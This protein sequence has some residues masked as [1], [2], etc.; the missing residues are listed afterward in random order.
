MFLWTGYAVF[1]QEDL[2]KRGCGGNP[3]PKEDQEDHGMYSAEQRKKAIET[4]AR[5]GCSAADTICVSSRGFEQKEH[6]EIGQPEHRKRA[7]FL[8][9]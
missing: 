6:R 8:S 1:R 9:G 5:F 3:G 4:F 2:S 7:H